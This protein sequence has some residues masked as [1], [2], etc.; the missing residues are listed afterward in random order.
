MKTLAHYLDD[1]LR[2]LYKE[3]E[4][5][6]A[7]STAR[8]HEM[9]QDGLSY[10]KIGAGVFCPK[11]VST[12]FIE[13]LNKHK[14]ESRKRDIAE[15]GKDGVILRELINFNCYFTGDHTPAF[16]AVESY[17]ITED[18]VIM[19]FEDEAPNYDYQYV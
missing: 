11:D 4:A 10:V 16:E 13:K 7:F 1:G 14:S 2:E 12:E 8:F 9:K 18:E 5:F 17:G 19:V 6:T 3:Y 15:N